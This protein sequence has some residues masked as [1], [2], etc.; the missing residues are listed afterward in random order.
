MNSFEYH[1]TV[2]TDGAGQKS[3]YISD[4]AQ[5]NTNNLVWWSLWYWKKKRCVFSRSSITALISSTAIVDIQSVWVQ[6]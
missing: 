3:V 1:L 4:K 2:E 6:D 5:Q